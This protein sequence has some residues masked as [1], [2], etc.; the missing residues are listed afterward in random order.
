MELTYKKMGVG[1]LDLLAE[2]RAEVLR[3]ANLLPEEGGETP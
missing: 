2:V 3:Q 1:D